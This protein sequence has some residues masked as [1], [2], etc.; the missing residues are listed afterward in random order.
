MLTRSVCDCDVGVLG[1]NVLTIRHRLTTRRF[2]GKLSIWFF[3]NQTSN[4]SPAETLALP[5]S[6]VVC[7]YFPELGVNLCAPFHSDYSR[8]SIYCR[9]S[10]YKKLLFLFQMIYSTQQS[11]VCV[12]DMLFLWTSCATA[13][14]YGALTYTLSW[15][16]SKHL[17][18]CDKFNANCMRATPKSPAHGTW[19]IKGA[20]DIMQNI[21]LIHFGSLSR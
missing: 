19:R 8:N 2:G 18:M 9:I 21:F 7:L 14:L 17:V 5:S 16:Y 6:A 12:C 4:T 1:I 20:I 15:S 13:M 11:C 10:V 3:R